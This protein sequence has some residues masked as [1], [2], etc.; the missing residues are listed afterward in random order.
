M[1][2]LRQDAVRTSVEVRRR[3]TIK[4]LRE[5]VWKLIVYIL[6]VAGAVLFVAP[7]AWMVTASLQDIGDMFKWPPNWIP[8]N[9]SLKNYTKFLGSTNLGLWFFNST[10]IA[11]A[12]T[13]LQL[14]FN[15]LAAYTFAKRRF[16]GRDTLFLIF[17]GTIMI[18]G[19]VLLIPSYIILKQIPLFGGND[20]FGQ[21]GHG[22]LDSYWGLIAPGAVST[23]GIFWLRQYM[24][25]IPDDLLDAARID[26]ASEFRLYGQVVLPLSKP[27][28]AAAAI[29][30]FT[31][32][33]NDWFWPLIITSSEQL[34]VL[35]LGLALFVTKNKV[36]WDIVFA[37]SVLVTLPVLI[38]FLLFQRQILKA[39]VLSGIK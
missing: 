9:P 12:I 22:W 17:L 3:R 2:V 37:G 13:F 8:R 26:G 7:F 16:P 33:W 28:L 30:T 19:Q 31:Y 11:L 24:K 6:L 34:R 27:A 32:A 10:Y 18:P 23:W 21:G 20:I 38:M 1:A 4:I 5:H 39:V 29:G 14:F 35:P 36:V 15:S 25:G